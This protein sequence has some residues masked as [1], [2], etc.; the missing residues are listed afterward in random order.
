MKKHQK[1]QKLEK[2]NIGNF[3]RHELA[4]VGAP[5]GQIQNMAKALIER[6]SEKKITYIDADHAS[7]DD[8]TTILKQNILTDK[9][10][11][12][13]WETTHLNAFDRKIVLQDQDLVLVNGNHF[14]AEKQIVFI[15]PKKEASLKKRVSQLTNVLA[16]V[17]CE[18]SDKIFDWLELNDDVPVFSESNLGEIADL[19][20]KLTQPVAVKGLILAGGKSTRMGTDKGQIEYH[21]L[22]QVDFLLKEMQALGLETFVSCREEQYNAYSRITDKFVD[23]GPFGAIVSAF[24]TDPNTAWLVSAVDLPLVD[25]NAFKMLLHERDSSKL[26]TCFYNPETGFPDPLITLWEPKSYMRLLEFL[27]LGYS[28]PRKVLINSEVKIVHLEN[29]EILKN[30]NTPEEKASFSNAKVWH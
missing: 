4:F 17:L 6:I 14:E 13:Q 30:I 21:G 23:L 1:H 10:N 18:G 16:I 20:K 25:K 8:E 9:I 24:Q 19:I 5:C 28:C 22:P 27:A 3:H 7:A 12:F 15:H 29:P 2:P 26:A 11:Y